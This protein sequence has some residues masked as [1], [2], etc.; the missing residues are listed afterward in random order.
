MSE[1]YLL[2]SGHDGFEVLVQEP[3]QTQSQLCYDQFSD[4]NVLELS[5]G[6]KLVQP[7]KGKFKF[8]RTWNSYESNLEEPR[9]SSLAIVS[10]SS[11]TRNKKYSIDWRTLK[12]F[13]ENVEAYGYVQDFRALFKANYQSFE[14]QFVED[15]WPR[16]LKPKLECFSGTI[17]FSLTYTFGQFW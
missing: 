10:T 17:E 6:T 12:A 8:S 15:V 1:V 5:T 13:T 3:R 7:E 9:N 4:F 16:I 14:W 2:L 11:E